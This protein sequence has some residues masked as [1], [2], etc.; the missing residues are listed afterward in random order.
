MAECKFR[1]LAVETTIFGEARHALYKG[2]RFSL[3]TIHMYHKHC[4][5]IYVLPISAER[6]T[7]NLQAEHGSKSMVNLAPTLSF[8]TTPQRYAIL[9]LPYFSF[10]KLSLESYAFPG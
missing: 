2:P 1:N 4:T 3:Y 9:R 5:T 8:T 7:T 6:P 10:F